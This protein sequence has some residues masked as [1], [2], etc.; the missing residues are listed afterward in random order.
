[1]PEQFVTLLTP[2]TS[3]IQQSDDVLISTDVKRELVPEEKV[4]SSIFL[5]LKSNLAH[6]FIP[7]FLQNMVGG[8]VCVYI[9]SG[10]IYLCGCIYSHWKNGVS[11]LK[12]WSHNL[13]KGSAVSR[14]WGGVRRNEYLLRIFRLGSEGI[15]TQK[16]VFV[17]TEAWLAIPYLEKGE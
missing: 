4:F 1:M 14:C 12:S 13:I 2:R 9:Y 7:C 8:G 15:K 5:T 3:S 11:M 16:C 10:Y 17:H 6:G